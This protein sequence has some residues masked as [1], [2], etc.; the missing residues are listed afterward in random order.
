V[1]HA[2]IKSFKLPYGKY[3]I[4]P[5][6][7]YLGLVLVLFG[8]VIFLPASK[9]VMAR[10]HLSSHQYHILLLTTELPLIVMWFAAF[11]GYQKFREYAVSIINTREGTVYEGFAK[12]FYWL[13]WGLALPPLF[14]V[15][16][17][18]IANKYQNFY[19]ASIILE[20]YFYLLFPVIAYSI[21]SRSA[22][23]LFT[24]NKARA[25]ELSS[26]LLLLI[27]VMLATFYCYL[28]FRYLDLQHLSSTNNPYYIPGWLLIL[29]MVIPYLYAWIVGFIGA[30]QF[31]VYSRQVKGIIY[32]RALENV[33][34]GI[35][36]VIAGSIGYQ[37]I[38]TVVPRTGRLSLNTLLL[39][40]YG[41]YAFITLGFMIATHGVMRLKRIEDI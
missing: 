37:Y 39:G 34:T 21:M 13:A 19:E 15:I 32:K 26:R 40:T 18:S 4:H 28:T 12:G 38:H 6:Y 8:L 2:I 36:L 3:L 35:V 23:K 14:G 20:N 25:P 41:L 22:Q 16:F 17:N 31:G 33:A 30:Y 9:V 10:Y 11:Y 5:I 24:L 1:R 7:N 27:F 29:T